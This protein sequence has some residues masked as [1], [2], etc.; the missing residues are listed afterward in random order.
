ML[1]DVGAEDARFQIVHLPGKP[2]SR[3]G[4]HRF[5][6][7]LFLRFGQQVVA[8][9]VDQRHGL[10]ARTVGKVADLPGGGTAWVEARNQHAPLDG[11]L[12]ETLVAGGEIGERQQLDL[13][14]QSSGISFARPLGEI[15]G[16]IRARALL[17]RQRRFDPARRSTD[18]LLGRTNVALEELRLPEPLSQQPQL[19]RRHEYPRMFLGHA[20]NHLRG[21]RRDEHPGGLVDVEAKHGRPL[22]VRPP[23]LRRAVLPMPCPL[24][25]SP[26]GIEHG[27]AQPIGFNRWPFGE[28]CILRK[29]HLVSHVPAR[30]DGPEQRRRVHGNKTVSRRTRVDTSR[31]MDG[32]GFESGRIGV[33]RPRVK[34]N[35]QTSQT[36]EQML[37]WPHG[38]S[39]PFFRPSIA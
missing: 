11:L 39:F 37:A 2:R 36:D 26:V 9:I 3:P 25:K 32:V 5:T 15:L 28:T 10:H 34:S 1:P 35:R 19:L 4:N 8:A 23:P 13:P 21:R 7:L 33:G 16:F 22:C 17:G 18:Q 31:R 12:P 29:P 24:G 6:Q 30:T 38:R 27:P 20:P 14:E